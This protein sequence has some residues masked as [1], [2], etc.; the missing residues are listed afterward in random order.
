M[1]Q[2]CVGAGDGDSYEYNQGAKDCDMYKGS[3]DAE[4]GDS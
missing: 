3:I 2:D 1:P 4:D